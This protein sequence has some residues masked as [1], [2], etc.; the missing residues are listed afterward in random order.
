MNIKLFLSKVEKTVSCWNWIGH[1]NEL[2][3][4]VYNGRKRIKVHRWIYEYT[5][6]V[7]LG[8]LQIHH[9]C[10]NRKCVNPNHLQVLGLVSHLRLGKGKKCK[11][12]THCQNKHEQ[13]EDNI[14]VVSKL[15]NYTRC[16]H[17]VLDRQHQT[18]IKKGLA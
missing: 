9:R 3:Y 16:R 1:V 5:Y 13:T 15:K 4:G 18:R 7:E 8:D 6:G 14:Y 11:K 2:G 10:E 17:C 12:R